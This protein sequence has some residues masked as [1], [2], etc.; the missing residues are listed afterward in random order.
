[1]EKT[2]LIDEYLMKAMP[3]NEYYQQSSLPCSDKVLGLSEGEHPLGLRLH[4]IVWAINQ[5]GLDLSDTLSTIWDEQSPDVA[6][7][8]YLPI[9]SSESYF[10]TPRKASIEYVSSLIIEILEEVSNDLTT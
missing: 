3:I 5:T 2:A 9:V 6:P 10:H 7:V 8:E 1:M 4:P